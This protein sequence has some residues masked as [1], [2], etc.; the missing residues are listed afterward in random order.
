MNDDISPTS[1][2]KTYLL[3]QPFYCY[4]SFIIHLRWHGIHGI[5]HSTCLV[6]QLLENFHQQG[7]GQCWVPES[8]KGRLSEKTNLVPEKSPHSAGFG[9]TQV[10][11]PKVPPALKHRQNEGRQKKGTSRFLSKSP[12]K[13]ASNK[14]ATDLSPSSVS[15][16]WSRGQAPSVQFNFSVISGAEIHAK[17]WAARSGGLLDLGSSTC[18]FSSK[19]HGTARPFSLPK[20]V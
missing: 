6:R 4:S 12:L 1:F 18:S 3:N 16:G 19:H 15:S 14:K 20:C 5:L 2:K 11:M 7:W 17:Q 10:V 8:A 13:K 9:H